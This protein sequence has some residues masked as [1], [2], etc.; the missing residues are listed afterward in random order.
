MAEKTR[1]STT[2]REAVERV[3]AAQDF[4]VELPLVGRV[5][6]PRPDQVAYFGGLVVLVA[7]EIIEWPIAAAIAAGHILASNHHN[8]VLEEIGE[9]IEVAEG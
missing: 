9:V 6:I 4:A 5:R 3:Q 1:H 7:L 2:H 8:T